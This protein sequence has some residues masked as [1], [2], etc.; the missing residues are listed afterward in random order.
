M[1]S[2]KGKINCPLLFLGPV[3]FFLRSAFFAVWEDGGLDGCSPGNF[4]DL[5]RME[6]NLHAYYISTPRGHGMA[7]QGLTDVA[8]IELLRI[9]HNFLAPKTLHASSGAK[10]LRCC[11]FAYRGESLPSGNL[12]A[13][14]KEP[15]RRGETTLLDVSKGSVGFPRT[16]RWTAA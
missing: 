13:H 7:F 9:D 5:G 1:V 6:N 11:R 3:A 2:L 8:V 15:S 16:W 10:N 14:N 4:I 12:E